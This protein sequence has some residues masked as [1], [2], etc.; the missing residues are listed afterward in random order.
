[1]RDLP[2]SGPQLA[3]DELFGPRGG[4][5]GLLYPPLEGRQLR[6][7]FFPPLCK[8]RLLGGFAFLGSGAQRSEQRAD[9]ARFRV[10]SIDY[11]GSLTLYP[12]DVFPIRFVS[13]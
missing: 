8:R 2:A 1:L 13:A 10:R 11:L 12:F 3:R 7:E 5:L 4:Q 6:L 9:L